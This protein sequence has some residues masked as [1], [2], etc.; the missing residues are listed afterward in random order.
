MTSTTEQLVGYWPWSLFPGPPFTPVP[1][2]AS[3]APELCLAVRGVESISAL[4]ISL[5]T[6]AAAICLAGWRVSYF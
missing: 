6:K 1:T 5:V 3:Q 4:K 2:E